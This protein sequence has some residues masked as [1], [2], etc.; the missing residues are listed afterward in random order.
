MGQRQD[1]LAAKK[2][3]FEG[4]R[5]DRRNG[6]YSLI[7]TGSQATVIQDSAADRLNT[8]QGRDWWLLDGA[9]DSV[10]VSKK[11]K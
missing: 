7:S 10:L 8:E 5:A 4:L 6:N 11:K 3:S 2:A 9:L 1:T